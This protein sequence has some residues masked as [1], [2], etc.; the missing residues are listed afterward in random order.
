M[1]RT[2]FIFFEKKFQRAKGPEGP[3]VFG[4][5]DQGKRKS[6]GNEQTTKGS[7]TNCGSNYI[8]HFHNKYSSVLLLCT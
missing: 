2:F 7:G 3:L 5:E 1:S 6:C 8:D 4:L